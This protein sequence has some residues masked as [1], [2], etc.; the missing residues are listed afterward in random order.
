MEL[1]V[2]INDNG[3]FT[4]IMCLGEDITDKRTSESSYKELFNTIRQ[5]IYIQDLEGRFLDVNDGALEI[6]G[7]Q[8]EDFIGKTPEFLSAPGLNDLE[9]LGTYIDNAINGSPQRF[10]FWGKKKNG[11]IFLKDMSLV[12]S[13]YFGRKVLIATAIDITERKNAEIETKKLLNNLKKSESTL[14]HLL[15]M[16][17]IA[18]RIAKANGS[19]VVFANNAYVALIQTNLFSVLGKNPKNYYAHK[20]EYETIVEQINNDEIIYN[21]LIELSINH[22]TVWSLASY[23]PI[24]FE[25]E[26]CVLGYFYD[27]TEQKNL[28]TELQEQ[29]EEFETIF[30]TSKDGIA[31]LDMESNFLDFNEAYLKMTGFS[32]EELL[33]T[34]CIALSAPEDRER[35]IDAMTTAA[36]IGYIIGFEKTCIVKNGKRIV[37]NM[38]VTLLPDKTR[39]LI[40]TKDITENK[41]HEYQLEHIAHYD[42]LT[43]LPNRVL[44]SDRL[45]QA[46]IQAVR[47]NEKIAVLYLDLDGFKEVNDRYGHSIGDQ[48]L[49]ALSI[50]LKQALR[51][52]DTLSRLGGDE[53]VV[54]LV[55][56]DDTS[57]ALPIIQRLLDAAS[58]TIPLENITV[59]VSASIGATFY[60]QFDNVDA[61]QL[62]RQADQAMYEAK[63]SGK[64]RYHIFD[65]E[66]DR[67]IRTRHES[68]DRIRQALINDEFV[69]YYQPKI[70][71]RTG[72]M[73]GAEA[74]IRWQHP[75]EG[76][77]PPL[78]FLPIIENHPL[79]VEVGEWVINEAISQIQRW[80]KQGLNLPISVN[81]GSRQLLQGE[82]VERLQLILAQHENFDSSL[83]EIEILETSALE[84]VNRASQIIEACKT[85]GI[86]F[87]LDD[88]GTGYSSLTYLKQLP[89]KTLKIDQ[90]FVRDMLIDCD[91]LA[92]LAGI[93][94]LAKAFDREVIA[95]GVETH[96]HGNQL[97]LLG[98]E[99]SQGYGI[100]RPMPPKELLQWSRK[101]EENKA[102]IV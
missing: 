58:K 39:V 79:A 4:G 3:K 34:S 10:E 6:Y 78:Q 21:R 65:A 80:Q 56:M 92:I 72:A 30:N 22:Q 11:D 71:M 32:R 5:A 67:T 1:F 97:L 47:R 63:Q 29:K 93:L 88:F 9:K 38:T 40:N 20:E 61:D 82:F 62:I 15:K 44:N 49:I 45:R 12:V 46:M 85:L 36:E 94:G 2:M 51:E 28:Q 35:A 48:L 17:P 102:W 95:E 96:E 13:N 75:D 27:I 99:L 41:N 68:L 55:N 53:F 57:M 50:Q 66:H 84:D 19:E 14:L 33:E 23:T 83:L 69:L 81:V 24:E 54:I 90:S 73:I 37:I 100:A 8:K 25:G 43:E 89:V 77:I 64:N 42:A 16:S 86:H 18:V 87:A 70:N 7:Y 101:W 59:Q 52:G 26:K 74:L 76:L 31:V 98:C 60:P 91:D